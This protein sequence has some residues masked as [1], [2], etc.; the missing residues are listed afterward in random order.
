MRGVV[1][2]GESDA[3]S[4]KQSRR[5]HAASAHGAKGEGAT[6]GEALGDHAQHGGPVEGLAKAVN[7]NRDHGGR[8]RRA[9]IQGVAR[10]A[11][12]HQPDHAEKGA[13]GEQADGR[14][15]MHNRS[16]AEAEDEHDAGGD[17]EK[18]DSLGGV[19]Q[20]R[21]GDV[22]DPA[23]GAQLDIADAGMENQQEEQNG[24]GEFL[25]HGSDRHAVGVGFGDREF[26]AEEHEAVSDR[27]NGID[28]KR[29]FPRHLADEEEPQQ[30][31]QNQPAG[32]TGVEDIE[33]VGLLLGIKCRGEGVDDGF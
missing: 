20:D 31:A 24:G 33:V 30:S 16:G 4:A 23:I 28:G 13:D 22:L 32:P 19:G 6:F 8:E 18:N 21:S 15:F 29:Y 27:G 1:I 9:E 2:L 26:L 25:Q 3:W 10:F 14:D 17:D 11:E 12:G 7:Q 5:E